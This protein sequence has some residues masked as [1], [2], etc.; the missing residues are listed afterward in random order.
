M[1]KAGPPKTASKPALRTPR[2][3]NGA[4]LVGGKPGNK[5]GTGRPPEW[6][7]AFCDEILADPRCT[8]AVESILADREHPMF[9]TM[10]KAC[11]DRAHG[12]PVQAVTHSGEVGLNVRYNR[13]GRRE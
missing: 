1:A 3:G 9:A 11:A 6:L 5:G 10:W 2:H 7:K 4:L 8:S 13:E 12:K